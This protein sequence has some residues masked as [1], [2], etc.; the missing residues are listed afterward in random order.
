MGEGR[1]MKW[2]EVYYGYLLQME[3]SI[4]WISSTNGRKYIMFMMYCD[5]IVL[6]ILF[7]FY[8]L[9]EMYHFDKLL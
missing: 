7:I 4:L 9:K 1:C 3:G 5:N 2:K 6:K 8:K